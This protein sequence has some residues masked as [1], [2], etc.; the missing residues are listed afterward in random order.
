MSVRSSR[1]NAPMEPPT[2]A[3][4]RVAPAI[5]LPASFA[6]P[7]TASRSGRNLLRGAPWGSCVRAHAS[8]M[9][10]ATRVRGVTRGGGS[11]RS[12][13]GVATMTLRS[14]RPAVP[15]PTAG[16]TDAWPGTAEASASQTTTVRLGMSAIGRQTD[17]GRASWGRH[18]DTQL[19]CPCAPD[20]G[21]GA[22]PRGGR[23]RRCSTG[24]NPAPWARTCAGLSIGHSDAA[25]SACRIPRHGVIDD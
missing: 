2:S 15:R 13:R 18:D 12:G 17:G 8:T 23:W 24:T 1:R 7:T 4:V 11:V 3:S 25:A 9:R 16:R 22:D 10:S 20:S 6:L 19:G 21:R 5:R 14:K